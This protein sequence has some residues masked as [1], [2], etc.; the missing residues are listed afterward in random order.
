MLRYGFGIS[1]PNRLQSYWLFL[2]LHAFCLPFVHIFITL[3]KRMIRM[4]EVCHTYHWF[5]SYVWCNMLIR[6]ILS[7]MS[8]NYL[9]YQE[10]FF[11]LHWIILYLLLNILLIDADQFVVPHYGTVK[12]H[13]GTT[14]PQCGIIVLHWCTKNWPWIIIKL[15]QNNHVIIADEKKNIPVVIFHPYYWKIYVSPWWL[16][17]NTL[18]LPHEW[19]N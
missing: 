3:S 6:T 8:D 5:Q 2:I 16:G 11:T 17:M 12:S 1:P 15:L 10:Q 7:L 9:I 4:N 13:C 19:Q 18:H 14:V